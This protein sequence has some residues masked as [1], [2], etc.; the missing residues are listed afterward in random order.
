MITYIIK[1]SGVVNNLKLE[2][3]A[4]FDVYHDT[5]SWELIEKIST[6]LESFGLTINAVKPPVGETGE[7]L[8]YE[9]VVLK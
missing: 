6:E 7:F 9:I 8:T 5:E 1:K 4:K 3:M 2:K